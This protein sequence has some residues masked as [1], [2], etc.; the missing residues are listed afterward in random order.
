MRQLL[1]NNNCKLSLISKKISEGF[2]FRNNLQKFSNVISIS[3]RHFSISYKFTDSSL[4]KEKVEDKEKE[5]HHINDINISTKITDSE[6][7]I[8]KS[9][10]N[11]D[12]KNITSLSPEE[13]LL[14]EAKEYKIFE[15]SLPEAVD[16][17]VEKGLE[18]IKG[19]KEFR[20]KIKEII[21]ND[22]Q[23][24]YF[25]QTGIV[26]FT[27]KTD[28]FYK[29]GLDS[30]NYLQNYRDKEY[31]VNI[32]EVLSRDLY[33]KQR[34]VDNYVEE[35]KEKLN[36]LISSYNNKI[37]DYVEGNKFKY[38]I[39]KNPYCK[40]K[41]SVLRNNLR[42]GI[43]ANASLVFG[44]WYLGLPILS[45]IVLPDL[46][47]LYRNSI[48][49]TSIINEVYLDTTR[50]KVILIKYRIFFK[51]SYQHLSSDKYSIS[52]FF[53]YSK[54]F[55]NTE[56]ELPNDGKSNIDINSSTTAI[57]YKHGI[58]RFIVGVVQGL[59]RL[60]KNP[61][62]PLSS[63]R[64]LLVD[65][66]SKKK[67][68][69]TTNNESNDVSGL[70]KDQFKRF[71]SIGI[72][73]D[74]LYIPSDVSEQHSY[75]Q[76][77]LTIALMNG[78]REKIVQYDFSGLEE[79]YSEAYK[80]YVTMRKLEASKRDEEYVTLEERKERDYCNYEPNYNFAAFDQEII[81]RDKSN[82]IYID[83]GYR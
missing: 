38:L 26:I 36:Y 32:D 56:L 57:T 33:E 22:K 76:E 15:D 5:I 81:K 80:D 41:I 27:K 78:E 43:V 67:N 68:K 40:E 72:K 24:D 10:R 9:E 39:Y 30:H 69:K 83:N 74:Y 3:K 21:D 13:K 70:V 12:N 47:K 23:D 82:G 49:F 44:F 79:H 2:I 35:R 77:D 75:T 62:F 42:S 64:Q 37:K 50:T 28:P 46:I 14:Q 19:H 45:I 48:F 16:Q 1:N 18:E 73:N 63:Y 51:E 31:K 65:I 59:N 66:F 29:S 53:V 55:I 54:D 61:F 8:N 58:L 17:L 52:D 60:Y 20:N 25:K 71:Y 11:Q 6:L 7:S 4:S 34:V